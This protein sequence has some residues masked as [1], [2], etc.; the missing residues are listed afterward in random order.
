MVA[1]SSTK[2]IDRNLKLA[3]YEEDLW[4]QTSTLTVDDRQVDL[5]AYA[6][7][8]PTVTG[9]GGPTKGEVHDALES[10]YLQVHLAQPLETNVLRASADAGDCSHQHSENRQNLFSRGSAWSAVDKFGNS[11]RKM[12]RGM[13]TTS[14]LQCNLS[15][16]L[17]RPVIRTR[18]SSKDTRSRFQCDEDRRVDFIPTV[19]TTVV[20]PLAFDSELPAREKRSG[21][22]TSFQPEFN[23]SL[24]LHASSLQDARDGLPAGSMS[25]QAWIPSSQNVRC[26]PSGVGQFKAV[27]VGNRFLPK[28]SVEKFK[29][30]PMDQWAFVN[31][32]EVHATSK[33]TDNDLRLAYVLQH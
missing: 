29:V 19:P 1:K 20:M 27:K 26:L 15:P 23:A 7:P 14:H 11:L 33:I 28:P 31:R 30:N 13:P 22:H 17:D 25:R 9:I 2:E 3:E 18:E 16:R 4:E 24:F 21:V 10:F 32:F 6:S 5:L 12:T 8:L